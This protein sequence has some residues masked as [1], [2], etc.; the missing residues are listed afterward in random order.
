MSDLKA[1]LQENAI[2]IDN[3]KF[4]ASKRFVDESGKP[5]EWE[6]QGITSEEDEEI[7]KACTKR[8]PVA[9]KK[10]QYTT[11]TDYQAYVGKLAARC[12]VYPNLNDAKLQDSYKVFGADV[13]L[14][15]M[16]TAGEYAEY[17]TKIQEIN[18]FDVSFEDKVEE[19]KN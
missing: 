8:I 12:T 13:L 3:V 11:E 1:F 16:L 18:G 9:G 4:V 2:K 6:I 19:A 5:I 17:L 15:R 10:Y 7:R 14:K